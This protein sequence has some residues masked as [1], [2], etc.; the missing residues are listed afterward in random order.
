MRISDGYG[1]FVQVTT[2]IS[3]ATT[4][5]MTMIP[6]ARI[7]VE[8]RTNAEYFPSRLPASLKRGSSRIS[9]YV[10][11]LPHTSRP[12]SGDTGISVVRRQKV[13]MKLLTNLLIQ[14]VNGLCL[15][16]IYT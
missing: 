1:L 14:G 10:C 3:L 12:I 5:A 4:R 15:Y 8:W 6:A 11:L 16:T 13:P 7:A 2:V 9:L